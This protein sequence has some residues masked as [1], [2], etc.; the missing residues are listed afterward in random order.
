MKRSPVATSTARAPLG[1]LV[2]LFAVGT[3][4]GQPSCGDRIADA[5]IP[6]TTT[7]SAGAACPAPT[8]VCDS[9][10]LACR[11]CKSDRECPAPAAPVCDRTTGQCVGCLTNATCTGPFRTICDPSAH[12][13]VECLTG[14]DCPRSFGTCDP[15]AGACTLPCGADM[16]CFT[17]FPFCDAG[18]H[19][20][21]EC[22][23]DLECADLG[24]PHC[25]SSTCT[26]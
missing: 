23:E 15:I 8:P 22:R 12:R 19:L 17:A 13:C 11:G 4:L 5:I 18:V 21:V 14:A 10:T 2:F 25:R 6:K 20:C 1:R 16:D 26:N 9:T 24:L 3:W 7:C